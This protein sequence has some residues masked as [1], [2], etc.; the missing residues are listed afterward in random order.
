[1][2]PPL[3]SFLLSL[4]ALVVVAASGLHAD[5]TLFIG[6]SYTYGGPD[7]IVFDH[8]GVPKI[9]EAIAA[10]KGK[11]LSTLMLT[12]GGV[13]LGYHLQQPKTDEDL[14]AKSW[15]WVVLQGL[16]ME[17]THVGRPDVF[18]KNG[19][20]F[21][22]RIM[23]D[24]PKAKIVLFQTWARPKESPFYS[25]TST[26]QTFVDVAQMN[27]EIQKNYQELCRRLQ[28]ID[29][30]SQVEVAPVG[31]A[32]ERSQEKYPEINVNFTDLHH[33]S[34]AGSYL[35]AL[36]IYA[37]I[38]QDSPKGATHEFF[39]ISLDAGVAAKLQEIADEVTTRKAQ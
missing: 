10:S 30:G 12:A 4:A 7:K 28:A 11:T 8:G 16:S 38:Y 23:A 25:G 19:E 14:K 2:K 5:D 15:D 37:T 29:P 33:A 22:K 27:A 39:G 9:V 6:N 36:V 31:L 18:F 21:C 3:K 32:F 34:T 20:I 1:M 13:D 24:S 26:P 35:A 17:A